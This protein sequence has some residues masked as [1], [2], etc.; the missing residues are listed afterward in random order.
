MSTRTS[1]RPCE[2]RGVKLKNLLRLNHASN[3][4]HLNHNLWM[5]FINSRSIVKKN[6]Q[7]NPK[8]LC[9]MTSSH[10]VLWIL[11]SS[12][13]HGNALASPHHFQ[14]FHLRSLDILSFLGPLARVVGW[15]L[16]LNLPVLHLYCDC[17]VQISKI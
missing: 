1:R 6:K 9:L 4:H 11:C 13:K 5:S 15:R 17:N 3:L 7:K 14:S 2:Q 16:Y 8:L 12:Q 10:L